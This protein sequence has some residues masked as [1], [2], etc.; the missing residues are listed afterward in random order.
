MTL[1]YTIAQSGN[2]LT[3]SASATA[4]GGIQKV[5]FWVDGKLR[6]TDS[7]A[8]YS[9]AWNLKSVKD[10]TYTITIKAFDNLGNMAQ[11]SFA[12]SILNHKI[13]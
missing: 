6:A 8:P 11:V 3:I 10:G 7:S 2:Y 13:V 1:S 4:S 12:V 5:Q 9:Y